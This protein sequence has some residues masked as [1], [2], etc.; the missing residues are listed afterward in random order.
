MSEIKLNAVEI[1]Y[2]VDRFLS[3]KLPDNF[4]PDAGVHFDPPIL[5]PWPTG[6]NLLDATQAD[7]MVRYMVDGLPAE[8]PAPSDAAAMREAAA[9]VADDAANNDTVG[10]EP[11]W[12]GYR[13]AGADIAA[14]IRA[15]P[16][17][18]DTRDGEIAELRAKLSRVAYSIDLIGTALMDFAGDD[19]HGLVTLACN[20][21]E[22][23]RKEI[24]EAIK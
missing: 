14:A 18:L 16:L 24:A 11:Y 13:T 19:P 22:C 15:L 9:K 3:W 5:R 10:N 12:R 4:S 6:T 7:A 23:V 20:T 21:A 2:M 8:S 1:K 17:P